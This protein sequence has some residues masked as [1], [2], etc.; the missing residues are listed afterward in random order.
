M[1]SQLE[2]KLQQKIQAETD[3]IL[4][5][6][7][8]ADLACYWARIGEFERADSIRVELRSLFGDGRSLKVSVRI[9]LLEGLLMYYKDLDPAARDRIY[10]AH[11]LSSSFRENELTALTSAWLSHIDFNQCNFISMVDEIRN[12]ISLFD[13]DSGTAS[14]RVSLVLGDAFLYCGDR[15]SSQ[16][17]YEKARATAT[18][19]GDQA[20]IGA[21]TYNRAALN[22]QNLRL[23]A[24]STGAKPEDI[25]RVR[26]ELKTAINYQDLARLKSLDHLLRA[27]TV[28]LHVMSRE[29]EEAISEATNL[30]DSTPIPG[31]SGEQLLLLADIV[32]SYAMLGNLEAALPY[33]LKAI[34]TTNSKLD[35]DD[36]VIICSSLAESARSFEDSRLVAHFTDRATQS[37]VIHES[38]VAHLTQLLA[39][40]GVNRKSI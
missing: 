15:V 11:L 5:A 36:A 39:E 8:S 18:E 31:E 29:Y 6:A 17:W 35:A 9:M 26:M 23:K 24:T 32:A 33:W 25:E 7:L 3:L 14:C 38:A 19:L 13:H 16:S 1:A 30:L 12:S 34:N 37:A 2:I 20:A 10:R 4:R 21:I 28:S 27:A 40:F 22:V